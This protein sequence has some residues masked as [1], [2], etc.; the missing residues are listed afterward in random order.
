LQ[1]VSAL[2]ILLS[3]FQDLKCLVAYTQ[4]T[5]DEC[6]SV[7][8][9]LQTLQPE[10]RTV[11]LNRLNLNAIYRNGRRQTGTEMS[12]KSEA[13]FDGSIGLQLNDLFHVELTVNLVV[14]FG[15]ERHHL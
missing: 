13:G 7:E 10:L 5:S 11:N 4:V 2:L 12:E 3:Y 14:H 6:G 9:G 1:Y 15:I 8:V